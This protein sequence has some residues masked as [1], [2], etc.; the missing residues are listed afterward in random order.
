MSAAEDSLAADF[1]DRHRTFKGIDQ[2]ALA[3]PDQLENECF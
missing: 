2:T 1:V 3:W